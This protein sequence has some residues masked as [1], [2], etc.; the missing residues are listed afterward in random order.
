MTCA[1][2]TWIGA[3]VLDALEPHEA[4][5][6]RRHI[7][8]CPVC[9]D[10][11][12]SLS[13]IPALLRTVAL[14]DVERL[15]E[16]ASADTYEPSA[17]LDRLLASRSAAPVKR[18][19]LAVV[20]G[21]AAAAIIAVALVLV[22]TGFGTG[23]GSMQGQHT[24]AVQTVDPHS[25]VHAAATLSNRTW[26]T[27]IHLRLSWVK[28][29]QRCSLIVHARDGST[30]VAASWT[31]NYRGTADVPGTTATPLDQLREVDVVTDSG[32]QL[33]RLVMPQRIG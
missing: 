33:A 1:K 23:I 3:Y 31:A 9:Q 28:P 30:G 20:L 21:A 27:E 29:G 19:R 11:V 25:Q 4:D 12:V 26:G 8:E 5:D 22:G 6:V 15:D 18:R 2:Q 10:E 17:V 14:E 13:W 32:H 7:A 16:A 24:V